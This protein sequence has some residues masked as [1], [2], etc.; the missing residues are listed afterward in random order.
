M[1]RARSFDRQLGRQIDV[2]ANQH[3]DESAEAEAIRAVIAPIESLPI[4]AEMSG[5]D[6]DL[7]DTFSVME[8][9]LRDRERNRESIARMEM[10][11][12]I[13]P[14][15]D[16][17]EDDSVSVIL[18]KSFATAKLNGVGGKGSGMLLLIRSNNPCCKF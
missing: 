6:P 15:E 4:P 2:A 13:G 17:E 1:S 3:W 16:E 9:R 10:E 14:E 11:N 8:Q 18:Y 12:G 7:L 5:S